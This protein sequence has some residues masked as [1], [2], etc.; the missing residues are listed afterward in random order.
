M[1]RPISAAATAVVMGT[2]ATMPIL[3]VNARTIST[4]TI[5]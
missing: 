5:S 2:A 3:P 4:A 1:C